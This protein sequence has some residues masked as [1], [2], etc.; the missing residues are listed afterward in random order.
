[1]ETVRYQLSNGEEIFDL[2]AFPWIDLSPCHK[3]ENYSLRIAEA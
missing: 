3:K 2:F 1:M